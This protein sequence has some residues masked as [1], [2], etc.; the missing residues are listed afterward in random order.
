MT[1]DLVYGVWIPGTGWLRIGS[2]I[3][4][5][6]HREVAEEVARNIGHQS[7]VRFVD[8]SITKLE[9]AYLQHEK[10]SI[11]RILTSFKTSKKL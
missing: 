10:E 7:C 6:T 2:A 4:A 9:E 11:W 1:N 8:E 5:D 3:F